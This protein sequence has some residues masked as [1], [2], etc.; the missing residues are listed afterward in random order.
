M[1]LFQIKSTVT[2][3]TDSD[4]AS[5]PLKPQ[6]FNKLKSNGCHYKQFYGITV[7]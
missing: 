2:K 5:K 7:I 1:N 4:Y 3:T 6:Q